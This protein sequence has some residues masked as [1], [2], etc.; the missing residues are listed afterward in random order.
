MGSDYL[1]NPAEFLVQALLGLVLLALLLRFLLQL[2]RADFYNPL[3]QV[4]IRATQPVLRPLRR[5]IPGSGRV[6]GASLLLALVVQCLILGLVAALRGMPLGPGG[7]LFWALAEL[8][9]LVLNIFFVTVVVQALLSWFNPGR[10]P[11][12]TVLYSLNEPLLGPARRLLPPLSG[13]DLS[14]VLVLLGLQL[15]KMLLVP[16]L[17]ELAKALN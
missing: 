6:D 12:A 11:L 4:I 16:P 1:L 10:N 13:L 7:L 5:V 3:S 9:A 2:C 15:A 17:I 8:L 14:P